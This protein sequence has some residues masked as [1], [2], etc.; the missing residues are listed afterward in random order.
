MVRTMTLAP[1][2]CYESYRPRKDVDV[3]PVEE[4]AEFVS[5]HG[6]TLR[7]LRSFEGA[8]IA[9]EIERIKQRA[10]KARPRSRGHGLE[11]I[12]A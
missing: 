12:A 1:E 3:E 7:V 9:F 10:A 11:G 6:F 8:A 4:M 5:K 2:A